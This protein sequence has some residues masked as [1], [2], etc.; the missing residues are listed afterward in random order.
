MR[1]KLILLTFTLLIGCTSQLQTQ[2]VNQPT[3]DVTK[4]FATN[5]PVPT[6]SVTATSTP[7]ANICDWLIKTQLLRSNRITA[8]SNLDKI[9]QQ[10]NP[11]PSQFLQALKD[12]R[13]HQDEFIVEWKKIGPHPDAQD[14]WEKEL[15][16]VQISVRAFDAM[17]V[18][19]ENNDRAKYEQGV[20]LL[21]EAQKDGIAAQVAGQAAI[22][23][24]QNKCTNN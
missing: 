21:E 2:T 1:Y 14:F 12:F 7:V 4:A 5:A 15:S 13:P 24:V 20:S 3:S 18:G 6:I 10:A 17:I 8:E 9:L 11:N 19:L 16:A 23:K 22:L